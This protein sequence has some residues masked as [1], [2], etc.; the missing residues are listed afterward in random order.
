MVVYFLH[1]YKHGALKTVEVILR[2]WKGKRNNIRR[3]EPTWGT[4]YTYGYMT[5]RP[6]VQLLYT[7][8]SVFLKRRKL[9]S[10]AQRMSIRKQSEAQHVME[11]N[12]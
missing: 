6:P 10:H 12:W 1:V 3:D 9:V 4:L 2:R 7:N 5:M 11:C 8:K